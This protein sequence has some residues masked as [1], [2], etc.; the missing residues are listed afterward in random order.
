M[1]QYEKNVTALTKTQ[2]LIWLKKNDPEGEWTKQDLSQESL[3]HVIRVNLCDF[4]EETQ[5]PGLRATLG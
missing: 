3:I 1:A 2:A 4:G 5:A